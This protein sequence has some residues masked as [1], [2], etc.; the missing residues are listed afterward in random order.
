[1]PSGMIQTVL[2]DEQLLT[3]YSHIDK[4]FYYTIR[5]VIDR[6]NESIEATVPVESGQAM[7]TRDI[8][9]Q[10][11]IDRKNLLSSGLMLHKVHRGQVALDF[12]FNAGTVFPTRRY[13]WY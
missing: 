11:M 7:E 10:R 1:M 9:H 4:L 8:N 2:C 3:G 12:L 6:I 13:H 5:T